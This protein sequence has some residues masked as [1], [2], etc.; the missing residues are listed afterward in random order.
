MNF[1][2][3]VFIVAGKE[4]LV[5][6]TGEYTYDVFD[7]AA[8]EKIGTI[9]LYSSPGAFDVSYG[10]VSR[11][12]DG[13]DVGVTETVDVCEVIADLTGLEQGPDSEAR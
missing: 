3:A 4:F 8:N 10:L 2:Y 12:L 9:E 1:K 13:K 6:R 11:N 5:T 7:V